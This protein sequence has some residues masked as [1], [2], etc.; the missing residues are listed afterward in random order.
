M[1][2]LISNSICRQIPRDVNNIF[3]LGLAAFFMDA[4]TQQGTN[5]LG[6]SSFPL[7]SHEDHNLDIAGEFNPENDL[8]AQSISRYSIIGRSLNIHEY[9]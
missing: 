4:I 7:A 3:A 6:T 1:D 9:P 5:I 2:G 8:S